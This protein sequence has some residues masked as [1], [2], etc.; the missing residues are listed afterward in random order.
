MVRLLRGG[1]FDASSRWRSSCPDGAVAT[2]LTQVD[3]TLQALH[4]IELPAFLTLE[5]QSVEV[6]DAFNHET[7]LV[8]PEFTL[9]TAIGSEAQGQFEPQ[10]LRCVTMSEGRKWVEDSCTVVTLQAAEEELEA[11][12]PVFPHKLMVS[13]GV[14][15]NGWAVTCCGL[16]WGTLWGR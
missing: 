6:V 13:V 4:C 1:S 12:C 10:L 3:S 8:C 15:T 2:G 16:G 7:F 9:L 5:P 11:V 14:E